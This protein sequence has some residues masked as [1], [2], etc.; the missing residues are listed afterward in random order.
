MTMSP[1]EAM[2]VMQMAQNI[3]DLNTKV[4][5]LESKMQ[6]LEAMIAGQQGQVEP[7]QN[8]GPGP[9]RGWRR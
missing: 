7:N 9:D 5:M 1:Q 6:M 4:A 8:F 2:N 3:Q